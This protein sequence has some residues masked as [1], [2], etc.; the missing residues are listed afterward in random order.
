MD[1]PA[2]VTGIVKQLLFI[3]VS[4]SLFIIIMIIILLLKLAYVFTFQS[5]DYLSQTV[6][7]RSFTVDIIE[8]LDQFHVDFVLHSFSVKSV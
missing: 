6:S 1:F 3:I 7:V 4:Q 8:E 2:F 5:T